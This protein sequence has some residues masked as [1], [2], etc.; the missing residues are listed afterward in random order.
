M[1]GVTYLDDSSQSQIFMRQHH[2][3]FPVIRDVNGDFVRSFGTTGVPENFVI[4][5]SGKIEALLRGPIDAQWVNRT[6]ARILAR[7][8]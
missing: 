5:R 3:T 6:L 2:L 8:S 4:G 1:L 7:Q